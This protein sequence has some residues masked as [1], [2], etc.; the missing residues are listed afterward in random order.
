MVSTEIQ[1]PRGAL[2]F[3]VGLAALL[4]GG[5]LASG[6]L[7]SPAGAQTPGPTRRVI[8]REAPPQ[9]FQ[10][11][12]FAPALSADGRYVAFVSNR[13]PPGSQSP[14]ETPSP[15]P[16]SVV[17]PGR[18][19]ILRKDLL[20][21]EVVV[22]SRRCDPEDSGCSRDNSEGVDSP[23]I[24]ADG[25][26]VAFVS[27][28]GDLLVTNDDGFFDTYDRGV[29]AFKRVVFVA[30]LNPGG[31]TYVVRGFDNDEE[32]RVRLDADAELPSVAYLPPEPDP[33]PGNVSG[34]FVSFS[35]QAENTGTDDGPGLDVFVHDVEAETNELVSVR[36]ILPCDETGDTGGI[37]CG[38]MFG[39]RYVS[40]LAPDAASVAFEHA[41]NVA[42]V[43]PRTEQQRVS[44]VNGNEQSEIYVASLPVEEP[45]VGGPPTA[46][47]ASVPT[48]SAPLAADGPSFDPSLAADGTVV[49]F[50][51][52]ASDLVSGDIN[53]Q[54]DVV[55]RD[56]DAD[57]TQRV[58]VGDT[59]QEGDKGSFSASITA[60]GLQVAFASGAGNL[61]PGDTTSCRM[62]GGE[63]PFELCD[64]DVFV[65]DLDRPTTARVSVAGDGT[66]ADVG[67]RN[68]EPSISATGRYVAF[69]SDATNLDPPD[70]NDA[71]DVFV[72]ERLPSLRAEP[73][74]VQFPL[75]R[76]GATD[77]TGS[78]VITND[79]PGPAENLLVTVEDPEAAFALLPGGCPPL[80]RAGQSCTVGISSTP[81]ALGPQEGLLAVAA[82]GVA[83]LEVPLRGTGARAVLVADPPEVDVGVVPSGG[84]VERAVLITNVGQLAADEPL[85]AVGGDAAWQLVG[86][87]CP[88]GGLAPGAS[89]AVRVAFSSSAVGTRTATLTFTSA[90]GESV[91]V[92]LRGS[93]G[94]AV[95]EAVPAAVDVG[96]VGL[97]QPVDSVVTFT[98]VGTAP[99]SSVAVE[100]RGDAS[101]TSVSQT[102]TAVLEVGASCQ[103]TARFSRAAPGSGAAELVAR[104]PDGRET[105]VGLTGAAGVATYAFDP[106]PV[107]FG[108]VRVGT[109]AGMRAVAL[110]NTS[111]VRG[112]FAEIGLTGPAAADFTVLGPDCR[113]GGFLEPGET[114]TFAVRA[115]P[116]APGDRA[117][118]LVAATGGDGQVRGELDL[119]GLVAAA[120]LQPNPLD[121][122]E[123]EVGRRGGPA[124]LVLRNTGTLPLRISDARVDG[125]DAGSFEVTDGGCADVLLLQGTTCTLGVALA[126]Q[127]AGLL[128][129]GVVVDAVG[130]IGIATGAIRGRGSAPP[131]GPTPPGPTPPATT[132]PATTTPGPTP[133]PTPPGT[134]LEP[135]AG[136]A[137][138]PSPL[139]LGGVPVGSE[140]PPTALTISGTGAGRLRID[141]I[142]LVGAQ[143][144]DVRVTADGCTGRL[145]PVGGSCRVLVVGR[146]TATGP[147][148]ATLR[149]TDSAA[150][151]PHDVAVRVRGL[152]P[153]LELV[154]AAVSFGP[155]RLGIDAPPQVL[156]ARNVG[157]SPLRLGALRITGPQGAEYRLP[158]DACSGRL[159]E[160]G[161]SCGVVLGFRP[162]ATGARGAELRVP[163][164]GSS[165]E[166]VATL[167]GSGQEPRLTSIPGGPGPVD[168]GPEVVATSGPQT[169]ITIRNDGSGPAAIG[170]VTIGGPDAGDFLLIRTDCVGRV[171][172]P[173]QTCTVVVVL[174]PGAQGARSAELR[175]GGD[176]P[177]V[178][179]LTGRGLQPTVVLDPPL[180]RTGFATRVTGTDFPAGEDVLLQWDAG[181]GTTE[182][183]VRP[184]GTFVTSVLVF[185]RDQTGPRT[186]EAVGDGYVV[187]TPYLV[188]LGPY[189]PP[190]FIA[191][192]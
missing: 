19:E 143:A 188:V 3:G 175:I 93:V 178:V 46:E 30:D 125:P 185:N 136:I 108:A 103:A 142:A 34:L 150:G 192:S 8:E 48:T 55:V 99:A 9:E 170:S 115:V 7:L 189:A 117:A 64:P 65:R 63:I 57:A 5:L 147:R 66:P 70:G 153:V 51:T 78:V 98:N 47:L 171:L 109:D 164:Q 166:A 76:V 111:S 27:R 83:R 155:V 31:G 183:R 43:D 86:N 32:G 20:T 107:D 145:L 112:S 84:S 21:G 61:V 1:P 10:G 154:P 28:A 58:S 160:P 33:P 72:R 158:S 123:R 13:P 168:L 137:L 163:R 133:G 40:S 75:Q 105:A 129:A 106:D 102:C 179:G 73:S 22:V 90:R 14:S 138:A 45:P 44:A 26:F 191:R 81:P 15:G 49:A 82:G 59:G 140:G 149:V 6:L 77:D 187:E 11:N 162:A 146:P 177:L 12:S 62:V 53:D 126:P 23:A 41:G 113:S 118:Q 54:L 151:S 159:L 157:D 165:A 167:T 2:A 116:G 85:V 91:A 101:W 60:D 152:A 36:D 38:D 156:A 148:S 87:D 122:G 25:R 128:A 92:P 52:R 94:Q 139:D 119:S 100:V 132:P 17:E 80:L 95:L 121:L 174:R 89:C 131:P 68:F 71:F 88:P 135:P 180:G 104:L 50:T 169:T 124:D 4:I 69:S 56:V 172:Q 120:V 176:A 24:S 130:D 96:T 42:A 181:L 79:G 29:S 141:G 127:R 39:S 97:D 110:R 173:G 114:C 144:G 161:A 74:P 182:V 35:S 37:A 67:S 134:A 18:V 186:S 190:G 16:D 184:D